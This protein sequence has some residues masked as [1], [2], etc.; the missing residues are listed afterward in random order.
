M[1]FKAVLAVA[2][3]FEDNGAGF[4]RPREESQAQIERQGG[5]ERKLMCGVD[6][7]RPSAAP[8]TEPGSTIEAFPC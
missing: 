5:A 1:P 3:V 8:E 4:L 7:C 6:V 2:I